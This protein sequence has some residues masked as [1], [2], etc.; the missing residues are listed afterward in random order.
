MMQNYIAST[1]TIPE[2]PRVEPLKFLHNTIGKLKII[3][4]M[5]EGENYLLKMRDDL[6]IESKGALQEFF[7]FSK[8]IDPFLVY[9]IGHI[10]ENQN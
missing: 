5:W 6:N 2:I 9:S 10:E 7:D 3:P 4:F 8:K 1:D